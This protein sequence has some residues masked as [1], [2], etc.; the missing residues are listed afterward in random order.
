MAALATITLM[1]DL[2]TPIAHIFNP[3]RHD[4]KEYVWRDGTAG[5]TILS[6][7]TVSLV[8]LP[9]KDKSV[10]R[11]RE[12]IILPAVET[13]T[14]QN[15]QGYTA[16]PKLAYSLMKV[17]DYVL[18]IRATDQQKKDLIKYGQNLSLNTQFSDALLFGIMPF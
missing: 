10:E 17:S 15:A 4:A 16:A 13:I 18:P 8:S 3:V 9:T 7:P 14:G 5:L 1:D 12:K 11:Y 2:T 6:A